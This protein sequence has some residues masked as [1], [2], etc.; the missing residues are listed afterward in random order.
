M[1]GNEEKHNIIPIIHVKVLQKMFHL[2]G[3]T[4]VFHSQTQYLKHP[5]K[6]LTSLGANGLTRVKG[7]MIKLVIHVLS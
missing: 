1:L 4:M 5:S 3:H 6:T 2:N 7:L